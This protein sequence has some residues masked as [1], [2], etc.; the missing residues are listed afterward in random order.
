M[1]ITLESK[2]HLVMTTQQIFRLLLDAMARPGKVI[3]LLRLPYLPPAGFNPYAMGVAV[4]LLD[5]ETT[6][7]V[8]PKNEE[9]SDYLRQNTGSPAQNPINAGYVF[10]DGQGDI[11]DIDTLNRGS[12]LRPETGATVIILI[13]QISQHQF[14][15]SIPIT[16]AGPGIPGKRE[17]FVSGLHPANLPRLVQLNREFPLG[18]DIIFLD[19]EGY[20]TC[21][22]R[23]TSWLSEVH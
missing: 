16:L 2:S 10:I 7:A 1:S 23:S 18:V 13:D 11:S 5:P 21:I 14:R 3:R 19:S 4:T 12:L 6:F 22:P 17:F 9:V 15:G 8:L 20:L